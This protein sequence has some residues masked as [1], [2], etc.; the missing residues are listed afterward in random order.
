MP[1]SRFVQLRVRTEYSI[2]ASI[3]RID[4]LNEAAMP[5][6]LPAVA[7]TDLQNAFGWIKLYKAA[8][9]GGIKPILGAD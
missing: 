8:R 9:V 4:S 2:S 5:G 7:M 6:S 3:V 1:D